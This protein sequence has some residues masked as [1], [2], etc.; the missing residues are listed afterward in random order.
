MSQAIIKATTTT[1]PSNVG[2]Q[3]DWYILDASKEP[4]G[5]LAS[6][7]ATILMGK[8]RADYL[9]DIDRGGCVVIINTN[10]AVLT[11][12]KAEKKVYFRYV[13]GH[14]GSLKSRSYSQQMAVD[15]TKPMY[16]ALKRML[17]KNRHLD[18]RM[19]N[20]VHIFADAN[21]NFTQNLIVAN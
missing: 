19:N 7:A 9:P 15:P 16:L 12:K 18:I 10:N 13:N 3:R 6:R 1:R 17:P 2:F 4:M 8:N 20:R 21:H 5:R 11:G 14:I